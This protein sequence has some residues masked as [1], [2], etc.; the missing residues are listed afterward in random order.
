MPSRQ[1]QAVRI[2]ARESEGP[3]VHG[4]HI[5]AGHLLAA[6]MT[7]MEDDWDEEDDEL[8]ASAPRRSRWWRRLLLLLLLGLAGWQAPQVTRL[9]SVRDWPLQQL[10]SGL[11]GQLGSGAADWRWFGPITYHDLLVQ[12]ADG[13][14][15]LAIDRL[16]IERS[17]LSLALRPTALGRVRLDGV[18]LT[19]AVWE[20]G[21]TIETMVMPWLEQ[22]Q[23]PRPQPKAPVVGRWAG[24]AVA[25]GSPA[26]LSG[27]IEV[28][29][30]TIELV[31]LRHGDSWW[32]TEVTAE[33]P[34]DNGWAG[35]LLPANTILSG[36]VRHVDQPQLQVV[37]EPQAIREPLVQATIASRSTAMMARAGGW[38][39]TAATD[40]ADGQTVAIG[41]TRV[42]AGISRLAARRFG[43]P[44]LLEGLLDIRADVGIADTGASQT[45]MHSQLQDQMQGHTQGSFWPRRVTL[46]GTLNGRQLAVSETATLTEQVRVDR[47]DTPFDLSVTPDGISIRQ[48]AV[49]SS[50]GQLHASGRIGRPQTDGV[51]T[52]GWLV[53]TSWQWLEACA[54]EDLQAK[55]QLDLAALARLAGRG[56]P[57]RPDVRVT[58]GTVECLLESHGNEAEGGLDLRAT[59]AGLAAEQGAGQLVWNEPCSV[60]LETRRLPTGRLQ[61]IEAGLAAPAAEVTA[62]TAGGAVD[63]TWRLDL[64]RLF[65]TASS[66]FDL[67]PAAG[68]V[69]MQGTVRGRAVV[70]P[71]NVAA[72]SRLSASLSLEGC[73]WT[74]AGQPLWED[75]VVAVDLEV[76]GG[77]SSAAAFL[78]QASLRVE[79]GADSAAAVLAGR[80]TISRPPHQQGWPEFRSGDGSRQVSVDCRLSGALDRWEP[81]LRG[82]VALAGGGLPPAQ[83]LHGLIDSSLTLSVV[84]QQWQITKATGQ[85]EQFSFTTG[86]RQIE[87][88]R[89]VISAAG[90]IDPGRGVV[91]L[92]TA[93]LL[94]A[95]LSLRTKGL[96]VTPAAM[97]LQPPLDRLLDGVRGQLQWQADLGRMQQWWPDSTGSWETGGRLWG[98]AE[99]LDTPAGVNLLV[100]TTGSHVSLIDPF[101]TL[102]GRPRGQPLWTEPQ[103]SGSLE[104]TRNR[105]PTGETAGLAINKLSIESS[106]LGL[107]A[108]GQIADLSGQRHVQL[109][110]TLAANWDQ[111]SR[112]L[113]P[114]G[115]GSLQ[116]VGGGPRPFSI[117][118]SLQRLMTPQ[119]D[120]VELPLPPAWQA[121]GKAA[122]EQAPQRLIALPLTRTPVPARDPAAWLTNLSA[123][124]TLAWQGGQI[125]EFPLGPGELPVR[126]FEGQLALGPFDVP[127]SGGR[128]RGA[129]WIQLLPLPGELVLPPGQ[130]VE[131]VHLS[132][133]LCDRWLGWLSPLLRRATE[134]SGRLSMTTTGGRFPLAKP[135]RG[136]FGGQLLLEDFSVTPGEMAGPLVNLLAQLQSVVDPRFAFGDRVVLLRAR[137]Q[138][139]AVQMADGRIHHDNL[140]LDMGQLTVRSRGSV[141]DDGSLAMQLEVAFRG[142][143][144]G[145]T[146][147]VAQ[148]LR[149]PFVI[150]LRGTV[151]RPQF[152]AGAIDTILGRIM[153]NTADAVLRDGI[154]RG[155]EALF[156][157]PQPPQQPTPAQPALTFPAT[158]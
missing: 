27:T 139:I 127:V 2:L 154:G 150:P 134:A 51:R 93:E 95:T 112:L 12:T 155:L 104:V 40:H 5:V 153:E 14:P 46:T 142:D 81:R 57:W 144:A 87:E 96:Q 70:G 33:I 13:K 146:P 117:E 149:T 83:A 78:E 16:Q 4:V 135:L 24:G 106:T 89:L 18:R 156:G 55:A 34:L 136:R 109:G 94:T 145:A 120:A 9:G 82:L 102:R 20:G 124:T 10:F 86:D 129:P 105:Q 126:L 17:P 77:G 88:P 152:D 100:E 108:A 140:I 59:V 47:L 26:T 103:L 29:D 44:L 151:R 21:S 32:V 158:P 39:V 3:R 73:A 6:C 118:G 28:H 8:I 130:L 121:A 131:R 68:P 85:I 72:A 56:L 76:V 75:D 58:G 133:A 125:A 69:A 128:V 141:G 101:N 137:P 67:Q 19:T 138:P 54:G 53:P 45:L 15:V 111:L 143:L 64:D 122:P 92:S 98:T 7:I 60:W 37:R 110:G 115:G 30:A 90:S 49:E 71:A 36:Q 52:A 84:D 61:L 31:D 148:L 1:A 107:L 74:V 42:P 25:A 50:L 147:V 43:W 79:A 62:T 22:L 38:A 23:Q 113:A 123:E 91:E 48:L 35:H 11:G 132:P 97:G 41:T 99:V 80:C 157:N 63:S 116:L 65:A 119:A 114:V 66:L